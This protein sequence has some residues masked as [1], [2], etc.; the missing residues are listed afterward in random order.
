MIIVYA[1]MPGPLYLNKE[2][3]EVWY[4]QTHKMCNKFKDYISYK[5]ENLNNMNNFLDIQT[6]KMK[7][8]R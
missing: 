3:K 5:F 7:S 8:R 6:T 4:T 2:N 1:T